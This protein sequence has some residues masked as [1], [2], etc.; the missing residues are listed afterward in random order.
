M[1]IFL[2]VVFIKVLLVAKINEVVACKARIFSPNK[3]CAFQTAWHGGWLGWGC[4]DWKPGCNFFGYNCVRCLTAYN[5]GKGNCN[6]RVYC[7]CYHCCNPKYAVNC[8]NGCD[9]CI[10]DG[11]GGCWPNFNYKW[12]SLGSSSMLEA[13]A[14][15]KAW[16]HFDTVDVDKNGSISLNEAIEYYVSKLENGTSAE[17]LAK[18][19]SWFAEMDSNGNNQ[20][21]PEEFDRSLIRANNQTRG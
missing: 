19:V 17:H 3:C 20:I 13:E 1:H 21:E 16:E 5:R 6:P 8:P 2:L 14:E 4:P 9:D 15:A 11:W 10:R 18:N 7:S 12:K